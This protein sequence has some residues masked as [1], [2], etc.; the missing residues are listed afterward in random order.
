MEQ[1]NHHRDANIRE[2]YGGFFFSNVLGQHPLHK[3]VNM[4]KWKWL[5]SCPITRFKTMF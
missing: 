4:V 2:V 5:K 1:V 3:L